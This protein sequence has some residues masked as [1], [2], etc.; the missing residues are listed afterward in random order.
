[1]TK[2][3]TSKR[4]NTKIGGQSLSRL[5][6]SW[7]LS[8]R[9]ERA[10]LQNVASKGSVLFFAPKDE[11]SLLNEMSSFL[12]P[13]MRACRV[14]IRA[15]KK[16]WLFLSRSSFMLV[17]GLFVFVYVFGGLSFASVAWKAPRYVLAAPKFSR[18]PS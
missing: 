11:A 14:P 4:E 15:P 1:M 5:F 16:C 10:K 2:P 3:K 13:K 9:L 8:L 6:L 17:V 18:P 12:P 7:H